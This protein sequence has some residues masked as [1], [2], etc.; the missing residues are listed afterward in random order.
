MILQYE[1]K[2]TIPTAKDG[3]NKELHHK[4]ILMLSIY[5]IIV[6]EGRAKQLT[7]GREGMII[8]KYVLKFLIFPPAARGQ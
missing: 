7:E 3:K 5:L 2:R 1:E 6:V 8:L 4:K